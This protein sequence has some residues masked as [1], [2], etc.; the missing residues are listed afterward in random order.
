MMESHVLS[1]KVLETV[2]NYFKILSDP[3][4]IRIL[5]LICC[6]EYAV[7]EIADKLQLG[8]SAVSHQLRLLKNFQLVQN[9]RKGTT[10]YYKAADEHVIELLHKAIEHAHHEVK[11]M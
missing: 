2:S 3:T 4:R 11:T 7:N 10:I 6:E 8:Q 1:D 5:N 9:R